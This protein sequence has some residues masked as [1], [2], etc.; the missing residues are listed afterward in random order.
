M[1][2]VSFDQELRRLQDELMALGSMVEKAVIKSVDALK[3]RDFA[4]S[5]QVV[6]DDKRLNE[7]RYEI[8]EAC[9][10]LL[11]TQ[12]PMAADLRTIISVLHINTDLERM[13]DYAAGIGKINLFIGDQ[14]LIKPLVDIP[15]MMDIVL[16]MLRRS[17]DAFV[18]RDV[19]AAREVVKKDDEVDALHDQV[20]RELITYML[21]DPRNINQATYLTWVAHN[22]ERIA[23][24]STNICERVIYTAT[25]KMEEI[26]TSMKF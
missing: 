15:R 4:A 6:D 12:Q 20:Y 24:R 5:R 8:E 10:R 2:R 11:A 26:G 1:T 14:P 17:L 21:Q 23:D 19:A 3:R 25:G 16:D 7:K 22:L 9:V 13:G 18:K